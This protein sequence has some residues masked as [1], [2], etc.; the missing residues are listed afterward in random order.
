MAY[1]GYEEAGV[2]HGT[3]SPLVKA[4]DRRWLEVFDSLYCGDPR[5]AD[6][7]AMNFWRAKD[8]YTDH[9][10]R[11][12]EWNDIPLK[13]IDNAGFMIGT[14]GTCYNRRSGPGPCQHGPGAAFPCR[15]GRTGYT[16]CDQ[17]RQVHLEWA[18]LGGR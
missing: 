9:L 8:V 11:V 2:Q 14:T 16:G 4:L 3:G 1:N 12:Y 13:H 7:P 6:V 5:P 17:L 18:V 10:V 15:A